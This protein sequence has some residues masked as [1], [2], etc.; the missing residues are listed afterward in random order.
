MDSNLFRHGRVTP[1]IVS[2]RITTTFESSITLQVVSDLAGNMPLFWLI[3]FDPK[4][5]AHKKQVQSTS[6]FRITC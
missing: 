6:F 4:F 2:N 5:E 3:I 1:K